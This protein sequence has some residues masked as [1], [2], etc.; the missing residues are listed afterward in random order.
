MTVAGTAPAISL[1]TPVQQGPALH[2]LMVEDS[3]ADT[4]LIV[5]ELKTGG[6]RFSSEN[7]Q[8][9]EQFRARIRS[10]PPDIVLADYNLGQW[11]GIEAVEILRQEGLDVPVILVTGALGDTTAVECIKQGATDYVLKDSLPKLPHAIRRALHEQQLRTQRREAEEALALKVKELART[12]Q[13]LEQ[14]AYVASH[15]LQEPLRMVAAYTQLLAEKYKGKLDEQADKYIHYAVDGAV[16]MQTLVHDLLAFSRSGRE[17]TEMSATDCNTI[18]QQAL[19]NLEAAVRDSG[20]QVTCGALPT[21][22]ANGGQ[23]RQ[24]F[25]NLIGNA[26]KFRRPEPPLV[27]IAAQ[28]EGKEWLF[29]VVDNGIGISPDHLNDIFVIFHRL[30]AREEYAGNGIGLAICKRIVERH[31]GMIWVESEKESGTTFKFSLPA[32]N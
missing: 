30:H 11:R 27:Q 4:D 29:S 14:F 15:D 8:T 31:G 26:I 23:L 16:R 12:N 3:E 24:V 20:A 25:Q 21:V 17:G 7:V 28:K 5:R 19:L 6:F 10:L 18:V 32:E 22:H 9:A 13:D 2:F 1:R